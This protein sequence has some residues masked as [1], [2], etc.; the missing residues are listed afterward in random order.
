MSKKN[1]AVCFE[2]K[3][4]V[5]RIPPETVE[6]VLQ[7]KMFINGK[8]TE[9]YKKLDLQDVRAAF[10]DAEE[11]YWPETTPYAL[12]E[13]GRQFMEDLKTEQEELCKQG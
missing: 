7:I 5:L 12:T 11:N 2:E 3:D 1:K 10:R 13:K 9:A 4:I 8:V 6:I